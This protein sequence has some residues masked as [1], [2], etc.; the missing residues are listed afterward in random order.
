MSV[1]PSSDRNKEG[2]FLTVMILIGL[3]NFLAVLLDAPG[4]TLIVLLVATAVWLAWLVWAFVKDPRDKSR[5]LPL[6]P[7]PLFLVIVN[8]DRLSAPTWVQLLILAVVVV[9]AVSAW[10]GRRRGEGAG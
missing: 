3:L 9:W 4:W 1:T 6:V 10:V 7:L 2:Y 5:Y 8:A